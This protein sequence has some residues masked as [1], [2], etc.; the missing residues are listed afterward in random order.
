[1]AGDDHPRHG[2]DAGMLAVFSASPVPTAIT[3]AGDGLILFANRA[4]LEML[5][6]QE[7]GFVGQTIIDVGFWARPERHAAMLAQLAS[8]GRILDLE[9]EVKT[10]SGETR[11]VLASISSVELDGEPC[12]IGHI[13]DITERRR[14]EE[15]LRESEDRFRQIT[16]NI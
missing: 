5:G 12:L 11:I 10:R 7:G 16:E 4:C 15:Q 6:W 1:M 3:R 13:H 9:E 2:L 8:E 14:L